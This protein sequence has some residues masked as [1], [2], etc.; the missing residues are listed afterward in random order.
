VHSLI[1]RASQLAATGK[2]EIL[3]IV[4]APGAG[5]STLAAK[6]VDERG[7]QQVKGSPETFD[8][9][10]YANLLRRIRNQSPLEII[11]APRFDRRVE[12]SI[13]GAIPVYPNTPLVITEGNYLLA[14]MGQWPQ[15]RTYLTETWY[16]ERDEETRQRQ[17]IERHMA[18]GKNEQEARNWALGS[19]ERNAT[20]IQASAAKADRTIK[21]AHGF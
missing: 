15:A 12:E 3:G 10:G 14:D 16:L 18:Y 9:T 4:G 20:I 8:D 5:K 6:L 21:I 17:L 19:D 13:A 7:L 1:D 2:R 11:Y